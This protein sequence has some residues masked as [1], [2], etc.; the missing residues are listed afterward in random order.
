MEVCVAS[1]WLFLTIIEK[2]VECTLSF[3]GDVAVSTILSF[4][5][6]VSAHLNIAH[7]FEVQVCS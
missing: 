3:S 5:S 7:L 6:F 2:G 1:S 4:L